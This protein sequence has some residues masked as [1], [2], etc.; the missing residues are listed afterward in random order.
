ML[1][2]YLDVPLLRAKA[3]SPMLP[4]LLD[5]STYRC[6][7]QRGTAVARPGRDEDVQ[8]FDQFKTA[9]KQSGWPNDMLC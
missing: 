5:E 3:L 4:Y 9:L 6:L 7:A 8:R 2:V 1:S